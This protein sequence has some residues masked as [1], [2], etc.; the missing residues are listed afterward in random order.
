MVTV[1]VKP[2]DLTGFWIDRAD[3]LRNNYLLLAEDVAD[4]YQ[5]YITDEAKSTIISVWHDGSILYSYEIDCSHGISN[6]V[7][8][9][10]V[11]NYNKALSWIEDDDD[12]PEIEMLNRQSELEAAL[13]EFLDVLTE[14][15][16]ETLL[17]QEDA[18]DLLIAIEEFLYCAYGIACWHPVKDDAGEIVEYPGCPDEIPGLEEGYDGEDDTPTRGD[19]N[20]DEK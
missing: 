17:E 9:T 12:D 4:D 20:D 10:M 16:T 13:T 7:L 19:A 6:K 14:G 15:Q 18:E 8:D 3:D 1:H 5:I 2:D 11:E